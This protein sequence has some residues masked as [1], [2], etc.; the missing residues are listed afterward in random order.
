MKL[1]LQSSRVPSFLHATLQLSCNR[2][3]GFVKEAVEE[4][5]QTLVA[6]AA[7]ETDATA[8][9]CILLPWADIETQARC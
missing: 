7:D 6:V 9:R 2:C 1:V 5:V 3:D 8:H 4:D